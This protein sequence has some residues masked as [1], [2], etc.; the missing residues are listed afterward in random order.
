MLLLYQKDV[1]AALTSMFRAPWLRVQAKV[2]SGI[3][4]TLNESEKLASYGVGDDPSCRRRR[5]GLRGR[6]MIMT[7]IIASVFEVLAA[8]T[9]GV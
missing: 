6:L 4:D 1:A 5:N 3:D 7:S 2:P 8:G 9:R